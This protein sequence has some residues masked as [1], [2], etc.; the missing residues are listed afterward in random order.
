[1]VSVS[2]L[3]RRATGRD[4]LRNRS[5]AVYMVT[6][7]ISNAGSF[8][9]AVSVPFVL[10]DLTESNTWVG[11]GT[12]SWML[13]SLLVTPLSGTISDRFDRRTVLLWSNV[14]QF[15]SAMGLFGLA[16]ADALTPSRI[17]AIVMLG[18]LAAGFQYAAAQSIAA[19]LLPPEQMLQGVRL[20]SVGFTASRAIGPAVAGFVLEEWGQKATFGINALSF[21][22]FIAGLM[23]ITVRPSRNAPVTDGWWTQFRSGLTYVMSRPALRLVVV[24]A[25]IASF[26]GQSM[27]QLAAGLAKE[28]F[29]VE[30]R[31]LGL[32]SA[33]YGVGAVS[34]AMLLVAGAERLRRSRMV[35]IGVTLFATGIVVTIATR[36]LAVGL[37]GFLIAGTAHALVG[38]SLNTSMQAQVE[39][40]Y[41]G[42]AMS[43]FLMAL[44]TG[45][46]FGALVG[47][48]VGDQIGLRTTLLIYA[49]VLIG[50]FVVAMTVL[51]RLRLLDGRSLTTRS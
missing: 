48:A 26:F 15:V 12:V 21:L 1:M 44:L 5:F 25:L 43:M 6:A 2:G 37:A 42:R 28:D 24:T 11:V 40:E 35:L 8:M 34:A 16:V 47:G 36:Q 14:L 13:P 10:Y 29:N 50:Y 32:L 4:L 31:G 3:E 22:V 30:G 19:V 41:R 23:T 27:V 39:E 18:G 46:P 49:S 51:R 38:T 17:V 45:M 33:V 9:Q 20:N 7:C